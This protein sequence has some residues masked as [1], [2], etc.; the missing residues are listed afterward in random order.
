MQP[1]GILKIGAVIIKHRSVLCLSVNA[2]ICS[3]H[4]TVP[5][6]IKLIVI[7]R[8]IVFQFCPVRVPAVVVSFLLFPDKGRPHVQLQWLCL[9]LLPLHAR[10]C[11]H[12]HSHRLRADR[13]P[14]PGSCFY[15]LHASPVRNRDHSIIDAAAD[16]SF[17]AYLPRGVGPS[18][19]D[20]IIPGRRNFKSIFRRN[21]DTFNLCIYISNIFN[22]KRGFK[23]THIIA[24][25][26]SIASQ[27]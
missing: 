23:L 13:H 20:S 8:V 1:C 24:V 17:R 14:H 6:F 27:M 5:V 4:G 3:L 19:C 2:L 11:S 18:G 21:F 7:G 15:K 10:F 9:I 22:D 25:N 16:A 26:R 12:G